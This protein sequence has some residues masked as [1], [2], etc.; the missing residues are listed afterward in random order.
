[1]YEWMTDGGGGKVYRK[2][3]QAGASVEE[4][5]VEF[6]FRVRP[7]RIVVVRDVECVVVVGIVTNIGA[8]I[9][10]YCK[11]GTHGISPALRVDRV[12]GIFYTIYIFIIIMRDARRPPYSNIYLPSNTQSKWNWYRNRGTKANL[13]CH[14]HPPTHSRL[15]YKVVTEWRLYM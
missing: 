14:R 2:L 15:L 12:A 6:W 4:N 13:S 10:S 9:P 7:P 1:M 8:G 3:T 5:K 11:S